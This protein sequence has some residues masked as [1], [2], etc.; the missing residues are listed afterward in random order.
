MVGSLVQP[1]CLF[2]CSYTAAGLVCLI[3]DTDSASAPQRGVKVRTNV[4]GTPNMCVARRYISRLRLGLTN[5][6]IVTLCSWEQ[7]RAATN[8]VICTGLRTRGGF[9]SNLDNFH[10]IC[11]NSMHRENDCTKL[12]FFLQYLFHWLTRIIKAAFQS[13]YHQFFLAPRILIRSLW[14]KNDKKKLGHMPCTLCIPINHICHPCSLRRLFTLL[15]S[16]VYSTH[17]FPSAR[18]CI[19]AIAI[20]CKDKF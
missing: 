19:P 18:Q 8:V 5:L 3:C 13:K 17:F 14:F 16:I 7:N 1:T 10:L 6:L 9:Y 20:A 15:L 4:I 12:I 11:F 2:Y